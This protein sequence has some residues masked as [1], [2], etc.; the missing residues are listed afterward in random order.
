MLEEYVPISQLEEGHEY[1]QIFMISQVN[2]Y[3]KKG[4]EEPY[5]RFKVQDVTG[6]ID[7]VVWRLPIRPR[8]SRMSAGRFVRMKV[9]VQS[10]DGRRQLVTEKE[11]VTPYNGEPSNIHDYVPGPNK[12]EL[13]VYATELR[14]LLETLDDPDYRNIINNADQRLGLIDNIL[15]QAPYNKH[16]PLACRGGLLVHVVHTVRA[17]MA[18]MESYGEVDLPLNE[19]LVVAGCVFRSIGWWTTTWFEGNILRTKD[20][21]YMTGLWRASFRIIHDVLINAESDLQT[22]FPETKKQALS[23]LANAEVDV[24][25]IEGKLVAHASA[26]TDLMHFGDHNFR[27]HR[28]EQGNWSPEAGDIFVGHFQ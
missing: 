2:S 18:L 23:N 21:A 4:S 14:E 19:S 8:G 20:A 27:S 7:G 12:A 13:E 16:G 25:T 10:Y 22:E 28:S 1:D 15:S 26:I 3:K 17:A 9:M 24:L 6:Q 5:V 11:N